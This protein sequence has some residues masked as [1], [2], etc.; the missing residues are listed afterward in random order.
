MEQQQ[1]TAAS[2]APLAQ[3]APALLVLTDRAATFAGA[4]ANQPDGSACVPQTVGLM[5]HQQWHAMVET[6][7]EWCSRSHGQM[8]DLH[9]RGRGILECCR[10]MSWDEAAPPA[11]PVEVDALRQQ[12]YAVIGALVHLDQAAPDDW[13]AIN[14]TGQEVA[15]LG[16]RMIAF[17]A[18][19]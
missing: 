17:P 16:R 4:V 19:P 13:H 14:A 11:T 10:H 7:S 12:W 8:E 5:S 15:E 18:E 9:D 1:H 3:L 6:L 2:L